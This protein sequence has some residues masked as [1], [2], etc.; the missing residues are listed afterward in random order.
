MVTSINA[1]KAFDKI[2]HVFTIKVL[3]RV[4]L[5][6]AYLV[7]TKVA[8]KK[9]TANIILNREKLEAIPLQSEM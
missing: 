1:E 8:Y 6:G 3:E 5:K 9:P 7:V 2:Q 4:W